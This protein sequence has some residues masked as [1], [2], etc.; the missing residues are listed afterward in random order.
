MKIHRKE[1]CAPGYGIWQ[2]MDEA[3][4]AAR[5][6]ETKYENAVSGARIRKNVTLRSHLKYRKSKGGA[7]VWSHT[8]PEYAGDLICLAGSGEM[9]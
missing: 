9:A 4:P 1:N 2:A 8:N 7:A 3:R 6:K 5:I